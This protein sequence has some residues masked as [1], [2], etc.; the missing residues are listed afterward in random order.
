MCKEGR[1]MTTHRIEWQQASQGLNNDR[2]HVRY[3]WWDQG[4]YM[5]VTNNHYK[6]KDGGKT[7]VF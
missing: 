6:Y 3:S 5:M 1:N 2:L 7:L 4:R